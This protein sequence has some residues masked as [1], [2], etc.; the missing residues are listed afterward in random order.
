M[1]LESQSTINPRHKSRPIKADRPS[2]AWI[3]FITPSSSFG[4][5]LECP[6]LESAQIS[7]ISPLNASLIFLD[8]ALVIGPTGTCNGSLNALWF[9][10]NE[11][12]ELFVDQF[13][14][15]TMIDVILRDLE[16]TKQGV[17]ETF[18]E[19]MTRWKGNAFRKTRSF[20]KGSPMIVLNSSRVGHITT[21]LMWKTCEVRIQ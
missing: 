11:L 14:F 13:I 15:N 16:T 6:A 4:P 9:S 2:I 3:K 7:W 8:L 20:T 21:P 12:V 1:G 19:Y 10:S 17:E 18:S 5:S